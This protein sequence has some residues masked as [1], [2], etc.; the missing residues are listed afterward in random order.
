[1]KQD[2]SKPGVEISYSNQ[3][4]A[5]EIKHIEALFDAARHYSQKG[6]SI[7]AQAARYIGQSALRN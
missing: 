2:L 7:T 6:F 3:F 1:M 4:N 5:D